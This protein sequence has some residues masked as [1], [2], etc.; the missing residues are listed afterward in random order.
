MS[1]EHFFD[2]I[3]DATIHE[4]LYDVGWPRVIRARTHPMA[5]QRLRRTPAHQAG[6]RS[7]PV[8]PDGSASPEVFLAQKVIC[9]TSI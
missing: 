8:Q 2:L 9:F 7:E 5:D 3:T 1:G 4:I 6:A